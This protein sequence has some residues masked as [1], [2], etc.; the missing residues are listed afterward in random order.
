MKQRDVPGTAVRRGRRIAGRSQLAERSDPYQ[1]AGKLSEPSVCPRCEAV[2]HLGRWQWAPRPEGAREVVCQACHRIADSQPAGTL[3]LRGTNLSVQK[4]E[5]ER[6]ARQTEQSERKE[7]ALNRI[8]A[9]EDAGDALTITTTDIHLPRRIG[10]AVRRALHGKL[11]LQYGESE[12]SLR[13]TWTG[14]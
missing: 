13:A 11:S 3:V 5:I 7:H 12:Y 14:E 6:I 10:E 8:M 9:I 1:L 2:Y 4:G